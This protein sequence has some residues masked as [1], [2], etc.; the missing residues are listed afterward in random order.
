MTNFDRLQELTRNLERVTLDL[1]AATTPWLAPLIPAYLA[2]HNMLA[3]LGFPLPLAVIG[4]AVVEFLGLAAVHTTFQFWQWNETGT[5]TFRAPTRVAGLV[6]VFYLAIV[7]TVNVILE[8][9][10]VPAVGIAAKA[11]LSLIS[12]AA[13]VVLALRSQHA[14][15]LVEIQQQAV[16][17]LEQ[18]KAELEREAE[19][20]RQQATLALERQRET[21]ASAAQERLRAMELRHAERMERMRLK[22]Q[23]GSTGTATTSTG[24]AGGSSGSTAGMPLPDYGTFVE[25]M[26]TANGSAPKSAEDLKRN[27]GVSHTTAYRWWAKYQQAREHETITT[28]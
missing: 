11:L 4:A 7:I 8:V 20:Q 21:D 2:G 25:F 14:R 6:G 16:S 27:H 22:S 3:V 24:S 13:G 19:Y 23:A 1:V 12:V 17:R 18:A 28:N 15:R 10:R 26:R 9:G 5:G